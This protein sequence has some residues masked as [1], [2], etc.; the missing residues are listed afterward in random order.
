LNIRER[1]KALGKTQVWLIKELHKYK[2]SVPTSEMS[3]ILS[4]VLTTPKAKRVLN[5]CDTIL[6]EYESKEATNAEN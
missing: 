5:L 4:G 3:Y 6:K 2:I 1:L